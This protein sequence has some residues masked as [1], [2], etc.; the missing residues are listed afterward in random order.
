MELNSNFNLPQAKS[1]LRE[2]QIAKGLLERIIHG[3][4]ATIVAITFELLTKIQKNFK[5]LKVFFLLF[6]CANEKF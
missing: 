4:Q 2:I 6:N 5:T 3:N 1:I